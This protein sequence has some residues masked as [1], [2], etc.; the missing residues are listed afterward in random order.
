MRHASGSDSGSGSVESRPRVRAG[1][2]LVL[3]MMMMRV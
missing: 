2:L 1:G 3:R